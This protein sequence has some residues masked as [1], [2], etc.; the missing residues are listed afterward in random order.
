MPGEERDYPADQ[1]RM[2]AYEIYRERR[3]NAGDDVSDWV[4]AEREY[5]ERSR[6]RTAEDDTG[7]D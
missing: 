3:G 6:D 4:Q 1:V 7:H 2:R 5:V